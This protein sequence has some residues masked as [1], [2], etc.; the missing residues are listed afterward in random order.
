MKLD[1]TSSRAILL[2][3]F[4]VHLLALL[5]VLVLSVAGWIKLI[6]ALLLVLSL[7]FYSRRFAF[8]NLSSLEKNAEDEWYFTDKN[9]R[10]GP[11][12]LL[13]AYVSQYLIILRLKHTEERFCR[14]ILLT[15]DRVQPDQFRRLRVYLKTVQTWDI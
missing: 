5:S 1:I 3:L 10:H 7:A 9:G 13:S 12:H 6:L 2:Y 14:T 15:R 11:M 4:L 8:H